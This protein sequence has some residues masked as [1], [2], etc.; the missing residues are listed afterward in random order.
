MSGSGQVWHPPGKN[1]P[2]G[3][4]VEM[5][6]ICT[7]FTYEGKHFRNENLAQDPA[8]VVLMKPFPFP[9]L[10]LCKL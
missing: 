6:T 9:I 8:K 1:Q 7:I 4:I 2:K 3:P 10:L 5:V